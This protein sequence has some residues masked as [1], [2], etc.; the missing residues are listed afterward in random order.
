ML[1]GNTF[2]ER[3]PLK[4]SRAAIQMPP[5]HSSSILS[6]CL[7]LLSYVIRTTSM[8]GSDY[9]VPHQARGIKTGA[10]DAQ[11]L[12]TTDQSHFIRLLGRL[13]EAILAAVEDRVRAWL[14][15]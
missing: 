3:L 13:N 5:N 10:F 1:T 11:G 15:L 12:G 9:E 4:P 14:A 7:A 8:R 2:P 6:A